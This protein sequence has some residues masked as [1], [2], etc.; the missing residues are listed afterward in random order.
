MSTQP[1]SKTFPV[2]RLNPSLSP[3][4]SSGVDSLACSGDVPGY[5]P[6]RLR[7]KT[8]DK[9]YHSLNSTR[10]Y[11]DYKDIKE[12]VEEMVFAGFSREEI[13]RE[14]RRRLYEGPA[15]APRLVPAE[16]W[17]PNEAEEYFLKITD[18]D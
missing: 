9:D 7:D 1:K 5:N 12:R 3:S 2:S 10:D 17:N 11:I 14:L 13:A 15:R 18:S 6:E 4:V 8:E 16:E